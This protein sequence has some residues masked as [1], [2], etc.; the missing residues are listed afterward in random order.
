M[1]TVLT[2]F[3]QSCMSHSYVETVPFVHYS[4]LEDTYRILQHVFHTSVADAWRANDCVQS[5]SHAGSSGSGTWHD[6][7]IGRSDTPPVHRSPAARYI[8]AAGD[9][10]R[11]ERHALVDS[12]SA[13]SSRRR[14]LPGLTA[15]R[16]V[17]AAA[18][19]GGLSVVGVLVVD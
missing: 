11:A 9:L 18:T 1:H 19:D 15:R 7:G 2:A 3:H 10:C 12:V 5:S 4:A 6:A 13:A 14:R 8:A 17:G 16:H